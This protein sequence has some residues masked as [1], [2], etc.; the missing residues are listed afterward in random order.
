MFPIIGIIGHAQVG[1]DTAAEILKRVGYV[2]IALAD[3]LKRE[4]LDAGLGYTAEQLWASEK[5]YALRRLLQWWGTEYRR[6]QVHDDYWLWRWNDWAFRL[7]QSEGVNP[8]FHGFSIPDV[9]FVNEAD[10]IMS[11]R[12]T[13]LD[14]TPNERSEAYRRENPKVA[15]HAS[16]MGYAEIVKKYSKHPDFFSVGNDGSIEEFRARIFTEVDRRWLRGT[17]LLPKHM[18]TPLP[19][20]LAA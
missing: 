2:R 20:F 7:T 15:A 4:V 1:K 13:V 14:I 5:C 16:E 3:P 12:G 9:R 8:S 6:A 19:M 18:G 10:F 11:Q 17:E